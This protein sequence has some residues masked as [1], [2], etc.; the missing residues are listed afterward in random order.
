MT[1][2]FHSIQRQV[3]AVAIAALT[4]INMMAIALGNRLLDHP[5]SLPL[6]SQFVNFCLQPLIALPWVT[7]SLPWVHLTWLHLSIANIVPVLVPFL[8]QVNTA[9]GRVVAFA[10]V[11]A[12]TAISG[13]LIAWLLVTD[14]P[15]FIALWINRQRAAIAKRHLTRLIDTLNTIELDR[16]PIDDARLLTPIYRAITGITSKYGQQS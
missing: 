11:S 2:P 15:Q 5:L 10:V 7:G 12:S 3:K 1:R 9:Y 8:T 13:G 6:L 14:I 4:L 16:L